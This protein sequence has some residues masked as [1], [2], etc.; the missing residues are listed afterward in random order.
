MTKTLYPL[1]TNDTQIPEIVREMVR[2][3]EQDVAD[4]TNLPQVFLGG[5]TG[6]RI[7]SSPSDVLA[8]DNVG[9]V[10]NDDTYEYKLVQTTGGALWDRRTL[11]VGW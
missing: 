9:D 11:D 4:F 10:V 3:R 5:R 6:V 8:T 2:L 7:P 1:I